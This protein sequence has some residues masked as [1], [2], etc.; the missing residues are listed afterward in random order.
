VTGPG[1]SR[2]PATQLLGQFLRDVMRDNMGNF[3][4][5]GPDETASNGLQALYEASNKTWLAG[6]RPE[7]ADGGELAPGGRVMEMLSEHTLERW[8]EGYV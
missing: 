5:F 2:T 8:A 3:R 4:V 1:V 7:D 6:Y